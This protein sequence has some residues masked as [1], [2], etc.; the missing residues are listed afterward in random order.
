MEQCLVVIRIHGTGLVHQVQGP[1]MSGAVVK[2]P[3]MN[4]SPALSCTGP[5]IRPVIINIVITIGIMC[6]NIS[7]LEECCGPSSSWWSFGILTLSFIQLF[8]SLTP[9]FGDAN[10][11]GRCDRTLVYPE[12]KYMISQYILYCLVPTQRLIANRK[13]LVNK[14]V[15]WEACKRNGWLSGQHDL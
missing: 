5:G 10:I 9:F 1:L 13:K 3:I 14:V 11:F 12:I 6:Q 2:S 8:R 4:T 7:Q 15:H